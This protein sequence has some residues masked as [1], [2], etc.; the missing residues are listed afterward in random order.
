MHSRRFL[1]PRP[2]SWLQEPF[3]HFS[4]QACFLSG[5]LRQR[6]RPLREEG[7]PKGHHVE[8]LGLD[9]TASVSFGGIWG[10]GSMLRQ[11]VGSLEG[12]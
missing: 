10:L 4:Y 8:G 2:Q 9:K 1:K 7:G 12:S 3:T 5:D 6:G 11:T